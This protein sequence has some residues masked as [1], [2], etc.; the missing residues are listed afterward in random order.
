MKKVFIIIVILFSKVS[1]AID[2]DDAIKST[3]ENNPKVKIAFEKLEESK[4]LIENA[5]NQKLPTIT[6]TISGTYS[7]S[8]SSTATSSTT[9]ETFTDK[10]KL[11]LTQNLYDAGEKNLEIERSKI[12]FDKEIINFKIS[13]QDLILS[14]I[15]GY[16][17][18]INYE[19]SLEASNKNFDSVTRFLD[20][21]KTKFDLGSATLYDLQNAESAFAIAETNLFIAQQNYD[22]SKITFNRIVGLEA[23]NLEDVIDLNKNINLELFIKNV[24]NNNYSLALLD[25]DILNTNLLLAI[26]KLNNK[27]SLD[28]STSVEYSDSGRIDSGTEKTNGTIGLTL[29]IPVFQKNNDK[30]DIRKYQSKLLQSELT[31]EDTKQDLTIQ[32]SNLYKNYLISKSNISSNNK[33]LKSIQTSLDSIKEEYKI[34]TKTITDLIDAE[35]ELLDVNVNYH[36]SRKDMILNYFN[37]LALE[38]SLLENFENYLPDYN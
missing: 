25:N 17:T 19:K 18:V 29:T 20:E 37:I 1:F 3:I 21:T 9:P 31:F 34:G 22:V 24:E 8:D 13:I 36:S 35:S 38:G 33:Q 30:S 32:A 15:N 10:Y 4:E 14:A 16:L 26:E 11:S 7:N 27:P 6:S 23:V 12:L 2:V 28:L 5:Y